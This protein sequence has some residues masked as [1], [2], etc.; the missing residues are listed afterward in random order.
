M[1]Y[2]SVKRCQ[3]KV[4]IKEKWQNITINELPECTEHHTLM[5]SHLSSWEWRFPL[6]LTTAIWSALCFSSL[7]IHFSIHNIPGCDSSNK[8]VTRKFWRC[9]FFFKHYIFYSQCKTCLSHSLAEGRTC[10]VTDE[11]RTLF[12]CPGTS[13]NTAWPHVWWLLFQSEISKIYQRSHLLFIFL[14]N[15]K[16]F[17]QTCCLFRNKS[18]CILS[19]LPM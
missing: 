2:R 17:K 3:G 13:L 14:V 4:N 11:T 16:H 1:P 19:E 9:C 5:I 12:I 7:L 15:F 10:H 8:I 18:L 6:R